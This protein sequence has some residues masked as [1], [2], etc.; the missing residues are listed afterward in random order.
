MNKQEALAEAYK[1]GI[2]PPDMASA[3]EEANKRGLLGAEKEIDAGEKDV[4]F[5]FSEM[6]GNIPSSAANF[7]GDMV[8]A[9]VHPIDTV[10]AIG[11]TAIGAAQKLIPGKQ[12]KEQHFDMLADAISGRYGSTDQFKRTLM[13]DPVGVAADLSGVLG[14]AGRG[15][16]LA[17]LGGGDKIERLAMAMD[18]TNVAVNAMGATGHGA[19]KMLPNTV[20]SKLYDSAAKFSTTFS[21]DK[22]RQL[23]DTALNEQIMP[24]TKG[25]DRLAGK[26]DQMGSQLD[27]MIEQADSTGVMIPK[28]AV[29][30][31]LGEL[32]KDAGGVR[33][34]GGKS[35][36]TI[37]RVAKD[38][39]LH[40]KNIGRDSISPS[41]LQAMKQDIYNNINFNRKTG[42]GKASLTEENALKAMGRAAK[43]SLEQTNPDIKGA[44]QRL[45]RLLELKEP[46]EKSAARIE[47][48][49]ILG[50][51]AAAKIT[52]GSAATDGGAGTAAG[53]AAASLGYP[54][55]KAA[56]ALKLNEL[57]NSSALARFA[58]NSE[59]WAM[60][61]Q[62]LLQG[63][64]LEDLQLDDDQ[65][66]AGN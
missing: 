8:N 26:I 32:R 58:N 57:Q 12:S 10:T 20:P 18:P 61:R 52:A 7:A 51:D 39:D 55:A 34:Y 46:I 29:M 48:R 6:V 64:R 54:Q 60:L 66:I 16:K 1:R 63:G 24:T 5:S 4:D 3:Y 19:A 27:A 31:H 13:E 47:N 59:G 38:F 43:E 41:E 49:N 33:I 17:K 65:V 56:T 44:N 37:D 28:Q 50:L 35:L 53:L 14:T 22:R 9:V 42:A 15:A 40:M 62:Y 36:D 45:G 30:R 21:P 23:V 25:G 2:L 11:N